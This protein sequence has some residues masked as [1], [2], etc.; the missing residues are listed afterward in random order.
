[1]KKYI[2]TLAILV[3]SSGIVFAQE[4]FPEEDPVRSPFNSADSNLGGS[5]RTQQKINFE[6]KGVISY[7]KK[8]VALVR[9]SAAGK[10]KMISFRK[11][12]TFDLSDLVSN[13]SVEVKSISKSELK[14]IV[15]PKNKIIR[16]K[17]NIPESDSQDNV[18]KFLEFKNIPL[19]VA[20]RELALV[21]G[22]NIIVTPKAATKTVS[23]VLQ[24]LPA[25]TMI[26]SLCQISDVW[27]RIDHDSKI[28]KLMTLAEYRQNIKIKPDI[29]TKFFT[30]L[31]PNAEVVASQIEALYKGRAIVDYG[32]DGTFKSGSNNG[33]NRSGSR[34]S[35]SYSGNGYSGS[36]YRASGSTFGGVRRENVNK[37]VDSNTAKQIEYSRKKDEGKVGKNVKNTIQKNFNEQFPIYVSI[38]KPNNMIVVR[39]GDREAVK[40]IEH[41]IKSLDKPTPQVL[42]EVK[43]VEVL[44]GDG[45][46]SV[47]DFSLSS[48]DVS[49]PTGNERNTLKSV[50]SLLNSS[51]FAYRYLDKHIRMRLELMESQR[52]IHKLSSPLL[53]CA[54]NEEATIFDGEQ[55]PLVRSYSVETVTNNNLTNQI[56]VPVTQLVDV[57]TTL[58][59]VPKINADKSV[60]M[61]IEQTVSSLTENGAQFPILGQN[62]SLQYVTVD[63]TSETTVNAIVLAKDGMTVAL[64]G[65]VQTSESV[66]QQKVPILGDLDYLGFFFKKDVR[67]KTRRERILLITP[68]V[69][70]APK[71]AENFTNKKMKEISNS[72][73]YKNEKNSNIHF[74][75]NVRRKTRARNLS[76]YLKP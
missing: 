6:I 12:D 34:S 60:T 41:L 25:K 57:G 2:I 17:M 9:A 70:A 51:T 22:Q 47:F 67:R 32:T 44:L 66:V 10:S 59:I 73:L 16:L 7:K 4:N 76:K 46:D 45:F 64:G 43:I 61:S 23:I 65:L 52:R 31:Y 71:D 19:G 50:G 11:N 62:N 58:K 37:S 26:E 49:K 29:E 54:N 27:H 3:T 5:T 40:Q 35:S 63:T 48:G 28:M 39:T 69:L 33:S 14:L 53:L 68:Y 38:N 36:G 42:L 30:L 8:F 18:V 13:N 56:L 24:N 21:T 15:K 75:A 72:T 20:I 1:M 74:P 55:R